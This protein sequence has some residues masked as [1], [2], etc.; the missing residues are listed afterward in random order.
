MSAEK[1]LNKAN[2][3]VGGTLLLNSN[4]FWKAKKAKEGVK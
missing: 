2:G 1:G 3:E 4:N